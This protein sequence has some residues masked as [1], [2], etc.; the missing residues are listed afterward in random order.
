MNISPQPSITIAICINEVS[1]RKWQPDVSQSWRPHC[2]SINNTRRTLYSAFAVQ[3]SHL[4][5]EVSFTWKGNGERSFWNHK[6]ASY[7]CVFLFGLISLCKCFLSQKTHYY[8]CIDFKIEFKS[9]DHQTTEL[10]DPLLLDYQATKCFGI[11]STIK[12]KIDEWEWTT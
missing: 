6:N 11:L 3:W 10:V 5:S 12:H 9:Q 4:D 1:A 2:S 7:T 8:G